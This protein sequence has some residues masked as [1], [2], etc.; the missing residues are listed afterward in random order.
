MSKSKRTDAAV[1]EP[2]EVDPAVYADEDF[3]DEEPTDLDAPRAFT[4]VGGAL[5]LVTLDIPIDPAPP[6][7]YCSRHV[8]VQLSGQHAVLHKQ[9]YHALVQQGATLSTGKGISHAGDVLRWLLDQ[10]QIAVNPAT[11]D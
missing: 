10:V 6:S 11:T 8:Q 3:D 1:S 4:P 9:I 2:P 5:P 7:G